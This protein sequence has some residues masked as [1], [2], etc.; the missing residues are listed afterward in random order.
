MRPCTQTEAFVAQQPRIGGQRHRRMLRA[1]LRREADRPS[2]AKTASALS[3]GDLRSSGL[4]DPHRLERNRTG[5][6]D[7]SFRGLPTCSSP[8]QAPGRPDAGEFCVMAATCRV[9]RVKS[10]RSHDS[11]PSCPLAID[12][13]RRISPCPV[14]ADRV[15]ASHKAPSRP[16]G[17]AAVSVGASLFRVPAR[18]LRGT[19]TGCWLVRFFPSEIDGACDEITV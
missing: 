2:L 8:I 18:V 6:A 3:P 19:L 13:S 12:C 14:P 1:A 5:H 11:P 17:D 16:S 7:L 10:A 4:L 9:R 15:L